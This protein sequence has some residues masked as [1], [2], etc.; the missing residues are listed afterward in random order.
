MQTLIFLILIVF[1]SSIFGQNISEF[2]KGLGLETGMGRSE[3]TWSDQTAWGEF[4]LEDFSLSPEIRGFYHF[5]V[6]DNIYI[7]SFIGYQQIKGIGIEPVWIY[8]L[9]QKYTLDRVF[10]GGNFLYHFSKINVYTGLG[11]KVLKINSAT[12]E[13]HT[14]D[15]SYPWSL[16]KQ[17]LK[18]TFNEYSLDIGIIANFEILNFLLSLEGWFGVTNL[19]KIPDYGSAEIAPLHLTI[20]ENHFRILL[21]YKL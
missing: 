18:N 12:L 2:P 6:V 13:S 15:P 11:L 4:S 7:H 16:E 10:V 21:G 17:D 5:Q 19:H 8:S 14:N 20:K 1:S 9:N 3:M